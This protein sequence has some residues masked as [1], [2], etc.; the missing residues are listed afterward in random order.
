MLVR[1]ASR[2]YLSLREKFHNIQSDKILNRWW[3]LKISPWNILLPES[4]KIMEEQNL[5]NIE[6]TTGGKEEEKPPFSDRGKGK[7][8]TT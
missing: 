8:M 4:Q 5:Y 2:A 7:I 3:N 6:S 1:M